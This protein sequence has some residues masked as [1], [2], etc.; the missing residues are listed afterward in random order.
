MMRAED[1]DYSDTSEAQGEG[2]Q[3]GSGHAGA[4]T[5]WYA[6]VKDAGLTAREIVELAMTPDAPGS[7]CEPGFKGCT[8]TTG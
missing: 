3:W 6:A 4:F 2:W 1:T 8:R 5:A 7:Q